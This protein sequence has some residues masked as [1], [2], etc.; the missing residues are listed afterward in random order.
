MLSTTTTNLFLHLFLSQN[1]YFNAGIPKY[2]VEYIITY[3]R[4]SHTLVRDAR[5]ICSA[6]G[7]FL[8]RLAGF[9]PFE[10]DFG[11]GIVLI[12]I[13]AVELILPSNFNF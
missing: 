5:V 4:I 10:P 7:F 6:T 13:L 8:K 1:D 2:N 3:K 12:L 9:L 11:V